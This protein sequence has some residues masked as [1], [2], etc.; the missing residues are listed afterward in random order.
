MDEFKIQTT[1]FL[2]KAWLYI[3]YVG[4]VSIGLLGLFAEKIRSGKKMGFWQVISTTAIAI[5]IGYLATVWCINHNLVK[6]SAYIVPVATLMSD[7]IFTSILSVNWKDI[8][9]T[10]IDKLRSKSEDK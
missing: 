7:K 3:Q 4:Y 5:F 6:E 1:A 10:L 9:N 8:V 2:M